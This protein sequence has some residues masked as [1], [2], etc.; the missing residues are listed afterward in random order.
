MRW[1]GQVARVGEGRGA[2]RVLVAKTEGKK[3]LGRRWLRWKDNT[4]MY[5]QELGWAYGLD[6]H[7]SGWGQF[8]GFCECGNEHSGSII[9]EEYLEAEDLS[10]SQE[11]LCS[12][13]FLVS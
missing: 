1:K 6:W 13:E 5:L 7:G 12:M 11:V 9:C 10:S 2:Y 4:Q 3:P 8:A